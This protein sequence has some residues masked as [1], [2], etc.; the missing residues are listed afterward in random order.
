MVT[1]II[2]ARHGNTFT[3][4]Q[5]PLRVGA[6]TDLPLVETERGTNPAAFIILPQG[7]SLF[8][9]VMVAPVV[10]YCLQ[11]AEVHSFEHQRWNAP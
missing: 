3:K 9:Y 2:I 8:Y 1:R 11:S 6:G 5:T 4:D 10:E 7:L